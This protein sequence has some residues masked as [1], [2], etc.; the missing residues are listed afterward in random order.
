MHML[1]P[2][3]IQ[4]AVRQGTCDNLHGGTMAIRYETRKAGIGKVVHSLGPRKHIFIVLGINDPVHFLLDIGLNLF[5][6][7]GFGSLC[8]CGRLHQPDQ[9]SLRQYATHAG[10]A[11]M[12]TQCKGDQTRLGWARFA[13]PPPAPL[14]T[15]LSLLNFLHVTSAQIA[16]SAGLFYACR[17][18]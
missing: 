1:D 7:L 14:S 9:S 18:G 13:V 8:W 2:P 5:T 17:A 3:G 16:Q 12:L 6:L 10:Y 15:S 11:A 4:E